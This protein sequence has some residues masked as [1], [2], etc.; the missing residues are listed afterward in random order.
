[1]KIDPNSDIERDSVLVLCEEGAVLL[2]TGR[3][4]T[5]DK[6]DQA[7]SAFQVFCRGLDPNKCFIV[8]L[9]PE[10]SDRE[11]FFKAREVC[12]S[13]GVHIQAPVDTAESHRAL[14][15]D[16]V[17]SK[18]HLSGNRTAPDEPASSPEVS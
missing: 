7:S 4:T 3:K 12:R 5:M 8:A 1:M 6:L 13:V 2:H 18:K 17:E 11:V 16:Y 9:I 15:A 14:W 10:D